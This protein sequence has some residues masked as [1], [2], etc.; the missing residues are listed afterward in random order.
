MSFVLKEQAE[1]ER[2]ERERLLNC[3]IIREFEH[4]NICPFIGGILQG[5]FITGIMYEYCTRGTLYGLLINPHICFNKS[6]RQSFAIDCSK[7]LAYLHGRKTIHGR[8]TSNNCVIDQH[9]NL[10]LTGK[11]RNKVNCSH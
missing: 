8:L 4:D 6:F 1:G 11:R 5:S 2:E 10:K 7:G 3:L 9:W